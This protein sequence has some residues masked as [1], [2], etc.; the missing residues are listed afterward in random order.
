MMS[1]LQSS[2]VPE[3]ASTRIGAL[4]IAGVQQFGPSQ[5][6]LSITGGSDP[7]IHMLK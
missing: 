4:H 2:Q 6:R 5:G 1:S 3:E 7:Y